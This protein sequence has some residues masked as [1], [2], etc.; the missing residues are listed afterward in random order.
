M[1][2][3]LVAPIVEGHGEVRAIGILLRRIGEVLFPG[4]YVD[5]IPAIRVPKDKMM[6]ELDLSRAIA[7]ASLKLEEKRLTNWRTTILIL[8]DADD[9]PACELGPALLAKARVLNPGVDV[10]C[11][12]AVTEFET[13]FAASPE[14]LTKFLRIEQEDATIDPESSRRGKNWIKQRF[15]RPRYS[16]TVDQPKMTAHL[17]LQLCRERSPSFEKL[18]RELS[19]RLDA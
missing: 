1:S 14:S 5:T 4:S 11:V 15:L 12:I 9:E 19:L 16:E 7:L 10:T 13:W 2:S 17:D 8:R 6:K 3:L 18:V